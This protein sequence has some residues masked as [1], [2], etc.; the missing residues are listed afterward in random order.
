M[1][2][3]SLSIGNSLSLEKNAKAFFSNLLNKKNISYITLWQRIDHT[4]HLLESF[5]KVDNEDV[6]LGENSP[7]CEE[8]TNLMEDKLVAIKQEEFCISGFNAN[9]VWVYF[10]DNLYLIFI[11]P[12]NE[13]NFK[14]DELDLLSVLFKKFVVSSK[15][16]LSHKML[17]H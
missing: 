15:A 3:L 16:C 17:L 5:P 9:R 2:E 1:F 14:D 7:L 8:L 13:P 11:R 12:E 6:E 4:L 10:S